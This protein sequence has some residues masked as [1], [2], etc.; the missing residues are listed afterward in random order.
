[1]ISFC[2]D[3]WV[4]VTCLLRIE[5]LSSVFVSLCSVCLPSQDLH[6]EDPVE[7]YKEEVGTMGLL[8][9]NNQGFFITDCKRVL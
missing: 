4:E 3:T 5:A 8:D 6:A 1:M 7:N 9:E 2:N